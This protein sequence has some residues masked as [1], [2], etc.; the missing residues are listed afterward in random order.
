MNDIGTNL[1]ESSRLNLRRFE[2]GD[3]YKI[4]KGWSSDMNLKNYVSWNIHTSLNDAEQLVRKRIEEYDRGAYNWVVELKKNEELI[5]NIST[6]AIRRN[7]SNCEIGYCYGSRY[8]N[9]GYATEALKVVIKYMF[10]E[11]DMHIIEAKHYS[12]NPASGKVLQKAGMI[13]EAILRERRYCYDTDS[14]ADLVYYSINRNEY[15]RQKNKI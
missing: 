2:I 7:H 3:A 8:W 9:K 4:Y 10:E 5:G 14:Y 6:V 11:C 1:I 15:N 12:T 13:K